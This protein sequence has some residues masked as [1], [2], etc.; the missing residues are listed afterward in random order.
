MDAAQVSRFLVLP[1]PT[2]SDLDA[3]ERKKLLLSQSSEAAGELKELMETAREAKVP[4]AQQQKIFDMTLKIATKLNKVAD[5]EFSS[6]QVRDL[7]EVFLNMDRIVSTMGNK[8]LPKITE[9][10]LCNVVMGLIPETTGLVRSTVVVQPVRGDIAT[11]MKGFKLSDP[12]LTASTLK[13][14]CTTKLGEKRDMQGWAVAVTDMLMAEKDLK[15][16]E[17]AWAEVKKR[18]D[19][20]AAVHYS[21]RQAFASR[22]AILSLTTKATLDEATATLKTAFGEL[23][24]DGNG[25]NDKLIRA[26]AKKK[27]AKRKRQR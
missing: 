10:T 2:F 16:I 24:D 7:Y 3:D 9:E 21:L 19:V 22:K 26:P 6:R 18:N 1:V 14:L 23:E 13:E 25:G 5:I 20:P 11:L 27:Q 8:D 15:L 17:G 4:P 12:I